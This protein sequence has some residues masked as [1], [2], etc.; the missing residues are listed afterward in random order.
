MFDGL[1]RRRAVPALRVWKLFPFSCACDGRE[2]GKG[3]FHH[4]NCNTSS[5]DAGELIHVLVKA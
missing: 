3:Q 1:Q 2:V 4:R 5:L